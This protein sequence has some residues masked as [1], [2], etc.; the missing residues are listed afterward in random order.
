MLRKRLLFR[1]FFYL[2]WRWCMCKV[3]R[4]R[5]AKEYER[6]YYYFVEGIT[7][8]ILHVVCNRFRL[9]FFQLNASARMK[10]AAGS[11]FC[12]FTQIV[13]P[14]W[15]RRFCGKPAVCSQ[16]SNMDFHKASLVIKI[17]Y[18]RKIIAQTSVNSQ[19]TEKQS[20]ERSMHKQ[21][22][23][24][25]FNSIQNGN[26]TPN[27]KKRWKE[28][29]FKAISSSSALNIISFLFLNQK[30]IS[31]DC[32][33]HCAAASARHC[34]SNIFFCEN[35]LDINTFPNMTSFLPSQSFRS[36][37]VYKIFIIYS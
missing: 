11:S 28:S 25:L 14:C 15:L 20:A 9:C 2:S 35:C 10:S 34:H 5:G 8:C 16:T 33:S 31:L 21:T 7:L 29:T 18:K 12:A 13:F 17:L 6:A 30:G 1:S 19:R 32:N 3:E 23:R 4:G 37:N 24:R 22:R 36:H 26:R 27:K